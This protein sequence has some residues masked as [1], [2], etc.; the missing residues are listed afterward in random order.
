V[1]RRSLD[2]SA[3]VVRA[4]RGDDDAFAELVRAHQEV[5]FGIACVITGSRPDA[6]EVVQDAFL[7]AH[8]ALRTFRPGAPF[9]PWFLTIVGNEARNRRRALRRREAARLRAATDVFVVQAA[10]DTSLAS[11]RR[12]ELVG[13]VAE[14]PEV[15]RQTVACRYFLDLSELETA[16]VLDVPPGT[17]KSR[18]VRA[19]ARLHRL[20]EAAA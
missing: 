16:A 18:L 8:R 17:V 15:E 13:A 7:K 5:A 10:P 9:R 3:V 4:R 14:L 19:L 1:A 20:L 6:E 12:Q 11:A 2:E